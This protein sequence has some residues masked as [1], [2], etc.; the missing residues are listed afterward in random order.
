MFEFPTAKLSAGRLAREWRGN[1]SDKFPAT[2]KCTLL[3]PL[4]IFW[5][6]SS[7]TVPLCTFLIAEWE[8]S[9]IIYE[10]LINY[11]D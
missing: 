8:S 6:S 7:L 1:V 5:S 4:L 10:I 9:G 11:I 3:A 2:K